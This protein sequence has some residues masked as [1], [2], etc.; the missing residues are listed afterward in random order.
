MSDQLY[1]IMQNKPNFGNDKMN[2]SI[3]KTK[4]YEQWTMDNEPTKTNPNKAN[5][6]RNLAKMGHHEWNLIDLIA[7]AP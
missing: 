6:K 5:F 3:V 1:Q 7:C 2:I 4:N